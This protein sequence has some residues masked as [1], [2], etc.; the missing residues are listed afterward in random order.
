MK[1]LIKF[2]AVIGIAVLLVGCTEKK[3]D[4]SY[5]TFRNDFFEFAFNFKPEGFY[6]ISDDMYTSVTEHHTQKTN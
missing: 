2:T 4:L 3:D 6:D 5:E 1:A